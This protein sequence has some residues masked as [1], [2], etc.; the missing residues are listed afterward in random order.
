MTIRARVHG[1]Y[2]VIVLAM[3]VVYIGVQTASPFPEQARLLTVLTGGILA[4][5]ATQ[6]RWLHC[7]LCGSWFI[8]E[9]FHWIWP[10]LVCPTCGIGPGAT[11]TN[12]TA[13]DKMLESRFGSAA[14]RT[15]DLN[16]PPGLRPGAPDARAR[17]REQL[18]ILRAEIAQSRLAHQ[19]RDRWLAHI[20]HAVAA[21]PANI[22]EGAV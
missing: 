15:W 13:L 14:V 9:R 22:G 16:P 5:G 2:A 3:G 20:D 1:T 18:V 6:S 7:G 11:G 12:P 17:R 10:P 8:R 4:A 21:L 19:D